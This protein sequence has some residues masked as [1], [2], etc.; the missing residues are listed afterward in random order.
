M[1]ISKHALKSLPKIQD[2][3]T[4]VYMEYV[5][6]VLANEKSRE[7]LVKEHFPELYKEAV[8][9][10]G[11][12]N[13]VVNANVK[14]VANQIERRKDVKA[15]FEVAHKHA[16]ISFVSKKNKLYENLY[17]M[18]IDNDIQPRDRIHASKVMLEHM[19]TFKEDINVKVE[20]KQTKED[21]VNHLR[22]IQLSLQK[23]AVGNEQEI[24]DV[25]TN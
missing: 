6:D 13:R 17:D 3:N 1:H 21:F 20:V 5:Q 14:K 18:A 24:I 19:P 7:E 12:N 23:T 10:A 16:W 8:D 15:M 22:E 9:K 4:M 25:Q 2:E 11:G